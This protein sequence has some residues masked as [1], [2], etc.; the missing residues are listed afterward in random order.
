MISSILIM[1]YVLIGLFYHVI[2][3]HNKSIGSESNNLCSFGSKALKLLLTLIWPISLTLNYLPPKNEE[4]TF[5]HTG[6][7][8]IIKCSECGFSEKIVSFIHSR[9]WSK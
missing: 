5:S 6:G 1:L 7:V 4:L 3:E 2:S 8:G 9:D